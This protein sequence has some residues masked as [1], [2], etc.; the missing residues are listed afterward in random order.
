M[1]VCLDFGPFFFSFSFFLLGHEAYRSVNQ[2]S[3][4]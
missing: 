3:I 2:V 4:L 1:F